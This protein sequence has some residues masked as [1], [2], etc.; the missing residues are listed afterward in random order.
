MSKSAPLR[1]SDDELAVERICLESAIEIEAIIACWPSVSG[2]SPMRRTPRTAF[3]SC[4]E[5]CCG[6]GH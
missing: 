6:S 5:R 1:V 3:T 4:A 2:S